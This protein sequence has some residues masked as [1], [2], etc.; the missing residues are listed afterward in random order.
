MK[1]VN[2]Q[3]GG[4]EE[5]SHDI[6][7]DNLTAKFIIAYESDG[8]TIDK[9]QSRWELSTWHKFLSATGKQVY[10]DALDSAWDL[11]SSEEYGREIIEYLQKNGLDATTYLLTGVQPQSDGGQWSKNERVYWHANTSRSMLNESR[12]ASCLSQAWAPQPETEVQVILFSVCKH[13]GGKMER[14]GS[15]LNPDIADQI[16]VE[17]NGYVL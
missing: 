9:K 1:L 14:T 11:F 15:R 10:E 17:G 5:L 6:F 16:R 2:T 4:K 7:F 8:R 3:S 13:C 12:C